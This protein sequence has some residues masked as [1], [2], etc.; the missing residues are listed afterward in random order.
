MNF[1]ITA[2]TE[3]NLEDFW[4]ALDCVARERKYLAFLE[5]PPIYTTRDFIL[6]NIQGN[7]PHFVAF[8]Q[9]KLVGW[10]DISSLDRPVFAHIGSL[11]MG[12][13]APYRSQG[14]GKALIATALQKAREK[15]LTRIE[16][17][18][19]EHNKR[20][21]ALYKQFGFIVEGIHRNGV[22]IDGVYENHVF[23]ALL[24]TED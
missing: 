11:G 20:A 12:V 15:G 1:E 14:I 5:A 10:C 7:W 21:I 3:E 2:I 17:T 23:M 24:L 22:C 19:R 8:H 9:G 18:V 13:L 6:Q 16:L 4:F